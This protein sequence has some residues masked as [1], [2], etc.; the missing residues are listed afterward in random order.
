MARRSLE[1]YRRSAAFALERGIII[2]DTKF[3]F[4]LDEQG[5]L[6]LI[7]EEMRIGKV[8]DLL[9]QEAKVIV[10]PAGQEEDADAD[11]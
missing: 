11:A 1:I 3:E 6:H 7:K 8:I 4:G 9:V 2:A 10:V 5:R